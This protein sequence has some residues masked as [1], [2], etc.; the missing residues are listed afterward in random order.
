MLSLPGLQSFSLT[1]ATTTNNN[2]SALF[3]LFLIS[4]FLSLV[5]GHSISRPKNRFLGQNL[6]AHIMA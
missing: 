2:R 1:S 6:R 3:F 5:H 4:S